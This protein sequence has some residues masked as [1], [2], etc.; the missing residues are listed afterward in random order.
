M[1][2]GIGRLGSLFAFEK[3]GVKPDLVCIAKGLGGGFPIGA[4]VAS[5]KAAECIAYGDHGST[6]GGNPLACKVALT[7]LEELLQNGVL[8]NV[9]HMSKYFVGKLQALKEKHCTIKSIRG[10]GLL[11]G[12]QLSIDTKKFIDECIDSG[13]VSYTHLTMPTNYPVKISVV[14]AAVQEKVQH[15]DPQDLPR[16][17][18]PLL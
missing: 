18:T 13:P 5:G 3:F 1:Q 7:I 11:L 16:Y 4:V 2:C 6:F 9:E 15:T 17:I 8:E 14:A 12:L 10:I